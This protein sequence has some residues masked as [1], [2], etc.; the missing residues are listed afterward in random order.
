[1]RVLTVGVDSLTAARLTDGRVVTVQIQ[2]DTI[3][4]NATDGKKPLWG[5]LS[6]LSEGD[7]VRVKGQKD[8][9]HGIIVA[10]RVRLLSSPAGA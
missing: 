1:M 5:M 6:S 10:R 8:R 7:I 4:K 2:P 9:A 3:L